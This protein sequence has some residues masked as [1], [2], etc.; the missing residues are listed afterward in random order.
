MPGGASQAIDEAT[1]TRQG[2]DDIQRVLQQ[3]PGVYVRGE[4]GFGLRPNIGMR[5]ANSERSAKVTLLE[6]GLP[7]APA[8]YAAP[9]AYY[10]PLTYRIVGVEVA[11]GPAAIVHGP[12]TIGGAVNLRTRAVP[13]HDTGAVDGAWGAFDTRRAH[14]WGALASERGGVLAEVAHL[15]TDGFKVLDGGGGTGFT[16]QDLLLKGRRVVEAGR[17][18]HTFGVKLGYGR[19]DSNETYLGLTP[20]DFADSPY[21]RYAASQRD[22][23]GWQ[24]TQEALTWEVALAERLTIES[25]A[26]HGWLDRT[27]TRLD[28][29]D[30]GPSLHDLLVAEGGGQ[31]ATYLAVLRGEEHTAAPEQRV[32]VAT[33]ARRFH[34]G[35]VQ[36]VARWWNGNAERPQVLELGL[37]AHVDRVARTHTADRF[38]MRDATLVASGIPTETTLDTVATAQA[39]AAFVRDRVTLGRLQVVPGVRV[40]AVRTAETPAEGEAAP[41]QDRAI[42]LPGV[43]LSFDA[44]QGVAV[45]GGVH[46]GFSPVAPGQPAEARPET[47]WNAE[48]GG[49]LAGTS[50]FAELTGFGSLYGDVQ[51]TCTFSAGCDDRTVDRQ[52]NGGDAWIVGGEAALSHAWSL[53]RDLTLTASGTWTTTHATFRSAF[54]SDFPQWGRV[55]A[56]DFLPYVP[57]HQG[58][59]ELVLAHARGELGAAATWRSAMR[60]VAGQGEAAPDTLVPAALVA[61]LSGRWNLREG[62]VLYGLARNVL[63]NATVESLRPFGA[64]PGAPRTFLVGIELRAR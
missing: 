12:Q 18:R 49:R 44:R 23:M 54:V 11:K 59:G 15:S 57:L 25:A 29:F 2:A 41:P 5:G 47:A 40:E 62:L 19:E 61:D 1:L 17:A 42:A 55:E 26:Y 36:T 7:L 13:D 45:F 31:A 53:P 52:F 32:V 64:R 56:G 9:A 34:A 48:L 14:A 21:R 58:S 51:G 38:D 35:G 24:H 16:R 4:D 30:G 43:A 60:D 6:D 28:A 37:R 10:F 63:D 39:L 3:V 8:P 22:R 50:T 20:T 27:W 46:R 33:N